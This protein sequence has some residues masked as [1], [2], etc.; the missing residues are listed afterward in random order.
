MKRYVSL[1]GAMLLGTVVCQEKATVATTEVAAKVEAVELQAVP[2]AALEAKPVYRSDV[3]A[4]TPS[5]HISERTPSPDVRTVDDHQTSRK[6]VDSA[7][8]NTNNVASA[9]WYDHDVASADWYDHDVASPDWYDHDVA[10]ADW[11]DHDVAS[12]DWYDH[13]VASPEW[14]DNDVNP[15]EW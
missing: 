3:S 15:Y 11:Y 7:T 4:Y 13:D 14:Y 8:D 6:S 1:A 2:A 10:S 5:Q 9:D 12:P